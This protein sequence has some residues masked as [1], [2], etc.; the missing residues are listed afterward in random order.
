M[1][2]SNLFAA[3]IDERVS[4]RAEQLMARMLELGQPTAVFIAPPGTSP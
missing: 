2:D 1:V 3:S 4:D